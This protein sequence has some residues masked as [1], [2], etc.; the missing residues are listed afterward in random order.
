MAIT[1][2][3]NP[4]VTHTLL[5]CMLAAEGIAVRMLLLEHDLLSAFTHGLAAASAVMATLY[6]MY[7][8][9][10]WGSGIAAALLVLTLPV[11]GA[12]GFAVVV[13]PA[14]RR[15]ETQRPPGRLEVALTESLE[16]DSAEAA[17]GQDVPIAQVLRS[18]ASVQARTAAVMMLRRMPT[19]QAVPLLRLAFSDPSE[20][21]RLLAFAILERQEKKLRSRIESALARLDDPAAELRRAERAAWQR[22]VAQDHWELV[23]AGFVSGG[24]V[25]RVLEQ[26][27]EH[28]RAA[29]DL[30]F[31]GSTALLLARIHLRKSEPVPALH[32]LERAQEAGIGAAACAPLCAE[33]AFALRRFSEIPRLLSCAPA[34]QFRRAGLQPVVDFWT[35]VGPP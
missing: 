3:E 34:A 26:A 9:P 27:V 1:E 16:S 13:L 6:V 15:L 22:R 30:E 4:F 12:L 2:P 23:Y 31:D 33:A 17:T 20:D 8:A 32:W 29:L 10:R 28:A 18:E 7:E 24:F 35:R 5:G 19:H 11:V 14:W 21:V 25:A